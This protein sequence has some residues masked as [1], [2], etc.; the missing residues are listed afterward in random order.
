[1]RLIKS[2]EEALLYSQDTVMALGNF[3]GVHKGHQTLIKY[4]IREGKKGIGI[5]SVLILDPHPSLV[6]NKSNFKLINT[7]EQKIKLMEQLGIENIFLLPFDDKLANVTAEEFGRHYLKGIFKT[8]KV[9]VGFNYSFGRK[10]LGTPGLL[11]DLGGAMGFAVEIVQ[12]VMCEGEIVSSTLIRKKLQKGDIRG[13]QKL[14]GYWPVLG[15]RVIP[16][17]Q[18]G[19]VLGFPTANID[20]PDYILLP[21]LGVYAALANHK[22]TLI[23]A[24]VNIGNKPTFRSNKITIEAHLLDYEQNLYDEYLEISLLKHIRP[25]QKFDQISQ[26]QHQVASDIKA[27]RSLFQEFKNDF[28]HISLSSK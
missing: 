16:G 21:A 6:F 7:T 5:P 8:Q 11:K 24:I 10:G 26:L 18:R 14:L 27:A 15:G 25:E 23:P 22:N 1:M 28:A 9:I 17:E 4:C 19:R 2:V 12:P 3:D 20:V 13:A